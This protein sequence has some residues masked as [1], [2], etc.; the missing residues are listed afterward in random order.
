LSSNAEEAN[1][2]LVTAPAKETI[3]P[4]DLHLNPPWAT[5]TLRSITTA[6]N[7]S[8]DFTFAA[9]VYLPIA[10][11]SLLVLPRAHTVTSRS[12]FGDIPLLILWF[13]L[14]LS[15][16]SQ[17]RRSGRHLDALQ[18]TDSFSY[19]HRPL[20]RTPVG[21]DLLSST[22]VVK[23]G[24]RG[25][26]LS[27]MEVHTVSA[28]LALSSPCPVWLLVLEHRSLV[29]ELEVSDLLGRVLREST[30][31]IYALDALVIREM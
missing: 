23:D 5:D 11:N 7:P 26:E 4:H 16:V 12:C 27:N 3:K 21:E 6:P 14:S 28:H 1:C 8:L 24:R 20:D 25:T 15:C 31:L 30:L 29:V 18:S 10:S 9:L 22:R 13:T 17:I 2:S 19:K